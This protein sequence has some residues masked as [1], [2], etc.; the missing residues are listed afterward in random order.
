M[1][2]NAPGLGPYL[3]GKLRG[4]GMG[5]FG[6]SDLVV[7]NGNWQGNDTCWRMALDL[8]RALLY[9]N[10]DGTWREAGQTKRC[11]T[12]VDGI[13][14]GEGNGPLCPDPVDSGVMIVGQDPAVVDAVACR[15]MG[16]DPERVPIVREAFAAHRWPISNQTLPE[17]QVH[18]ERVGKLVPLREV[19]PA[20][21]GGF[22]P[23]FGWTNLG[24]EG[25]SE[26]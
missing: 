10:P 3:F 11:L 6:D 14:G 25:S 1:A 17:I 18:D 24:K 2:I 8:N 7:R 4:V 12:I 5:M 20:V 19:A 26:R 16:F 13:I 21:P 15:L 9:G 23:H 22:K